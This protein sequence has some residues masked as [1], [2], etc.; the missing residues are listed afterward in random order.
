MTPP[1]FMLRPGLAGRNFRNALVSLTLAVAASTPAPA[2]EL[3]DFAAPAKS[4][5]SEG[6]Q[7]EQNLCMKREAE[8]TERRLQER[9]S[10]LTRSLRDSTS[11][12]RAQGAWK[13]FRD[14][15]CEFANSGVDKAHS[16]YEF[17]VYAC[18]IDRG[19]KRARDLDMHLEADCNGCPPRK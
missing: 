12:T 19:E 9:A 4:R 5:C 13:S 18:R 14:R 16:L 1:A 17:G 7:L 2:Q 11:F 10:K 3:W 15:E 6:N 8:R